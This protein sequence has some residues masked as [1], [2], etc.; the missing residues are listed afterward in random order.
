M[1]R[2]PLALIRNFRILPP[3][4]KWLTN[5]A[6]FWLVGKSNNKTEITTNQQPAVRFLK[7]YLEMFLTCSHHRCLRFILF[8]ELF[9]KIPFLYFC[10]AGKWK[11]N[12][13]L[14]INI[15]WKP[16]KIYSKDQRRFLYKIRE[17]KHGT[18]LSQGWQPE[19][20]YFP[21]S[22]AFTLPQLYYE[23]S[24]H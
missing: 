13:F 18:I 24:F 14:T 12:F 11:F 5:F 2:K 1:L 23:V 7:A 21:V 16:E 8:K 3:F 17:L 20:S 22:H 15:N 9:D 10:I 19:V 6:L 4:I